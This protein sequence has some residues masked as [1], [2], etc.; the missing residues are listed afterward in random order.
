MKVNGSPDYRNNMAKVQSTSHFIQG[1]EFTELVMSKAKQLN[2]QRSA[3]YVLPL[4]TKGDP[5]LK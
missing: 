4:K 3:K 1:D 2:L 5:K